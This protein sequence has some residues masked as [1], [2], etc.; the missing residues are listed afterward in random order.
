MTI[1]ITQTVNLE[2][3]SCGKGAV[4]LCGDPNDIDPVAWVA[5]GACGVYVTKALRLKKYNSDCISVLAGKRKILKH[6][7]ENYLVTQTKKRKK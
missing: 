5:N 4:W 3:V 1:Q 2:W 6:L 7:R